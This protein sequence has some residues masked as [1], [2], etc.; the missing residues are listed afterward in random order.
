MN[1]RTFLPV[2]WP[3]LLLLLGFLLDPL[4]GQ[5]EDHRQTAALLQEGRTRLEGLRAKTVAGRLDTL[6]YREL[7]AQ[8]AAL[9]NLQASDP[10]RDPGV[11]ALGTVQVASLI[12]GLQRALSQP[13]PPDQPERLEFLS[14][15]PGVQQQIS[16]F[17]TV[18]FA[19]NLRGRFRAIP[20]FLDLLTNIGRSRNLAISVGALR[21]ESTSETPTTGELTITLPVRAY[22]RE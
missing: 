18:E 7:V 16:P 14:V 5:L 15:S 3:L 11:K 4:L 20:A 13:L 6:E 21:I 8:F 22:F 9:T 1:R 10:F 2:I 12:D 17:V 19:L